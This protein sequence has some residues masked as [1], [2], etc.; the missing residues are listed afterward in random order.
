VS[1][2][3]LGFGVWIHHMF[4]TGIAPLT[5]SFFSAGSIVI[6]VPSAV[7]VFAWIATIYHGRPVFKTPFL[8]A[9]GF[10]VLFVL[11]G[12]SGVMTAL[13]P[14]DWQ[15]TDT[16]FVV[17]HLHYVLIGINVFPVLAG[18]YY[19]LPKMTGRM[20]NERLGKWN[21]WTMFI[22]FNIGFFPMHIA[23]LLGMPRRIYTY[24]PGLGWDTLNLIETIGAFL[25]GFGLLLF[26]VNFFWSRRNGARAP[27]NPW[28][29][30]TLEWATSSPPPPYNFSIIPLVGSRHPLWENRIVEGTASSDFRS[31]PVLTEDKQTPGTTP[32]DAEPLTV[33]HMPEDSYAPLML[34][35]SL[36]VFFYGA[37]VTQLWLA[38][39][40]ILLV[41]ATMVSWLWP[42]AELPHAQDLLAKKSLG[43]WAMVWTV[44][45]E[46][47]LFAYFLFAYFYLG[48]MSARAWPPNGPPDLKLAFPNTIVL[49]ASSATMFWAETAIKRDEQ[50]KARLALFITFVLGLIFLIV[51]GFE[52]SA[53]SFGISNDAYSSLFYTITGFHGAHVAVG[54]L[55][56][57]FVQVLAWRGY[58]NSKKH[59]AFSNAALYWHFVDAV[60]VCV[61]TCLYLV[62]Q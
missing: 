2:G 26:V 34:A 50:G 41:G 17:A 38:I 47:S 48:S 13:V 39:I 22:G 56:N 54:L 44:I 51:Q 31:G 30:P 43:W 49:L 4:A 55:M 3:I 27:A 5:A 28:D 25:F 37:L 52:Y 16:Y 32:L 20:L 1:T 62:A 33:F 58:F 7:A 18:L 8:F 19:W 12:V 42:A 45:T 11:G 36:T 24:A 35:F 57:L 53:K 23:G 15:L 46:A 60:W 14:F 9:A 29:A 6:S 10:I 61:F 40:G 59:V 21:F